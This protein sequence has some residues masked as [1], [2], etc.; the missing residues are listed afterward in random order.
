M[1]TYTEITVNGM[2]PQLPIKGGLT[3]QPETLL[4]SVH[5]ASWYICNISFPPL[6]N[7]CYPPSRR[8]H[9]APSGRSFRMLALA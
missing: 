7:N 2:T 6:R 4:S 3:I 1:G 9:W 8:A 5:S